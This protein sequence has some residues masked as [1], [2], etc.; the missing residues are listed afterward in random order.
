MFHQ[1]K[2]GEFD[3]DEDAIEE[4]YEALL[5]ESAL[6]GFVQYEVANFAKE[7]RKDSSDRVPS[8][9]CQHNINYWRCG[10]YFGVGPAA[11]EWVAGMRNQHCQYGNYSQ[12]VGQGQRGL[13]SEAVHPSTRLGEAAAF[14]MRMNA[15]ID[16]AAFQGRFGCIRSPLGITNES[17]GGSRLGSL[18]TNLLS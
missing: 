6:H 7:I 16:F 14:S 13:I 9:A 8:H 3:V 1:L 10:D 15:G 2:A 5:E 11:S 17:N 18:G 12:Q 4:M